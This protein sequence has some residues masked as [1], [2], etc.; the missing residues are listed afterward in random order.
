M[1]LS[2]HR[3]AG[4]RLVR[5]L[6]GGKRKAPHPDAPQGEIIS[7]FP[8]LGDENQPAIPS[9]VQL[10][11]LISSARLLKSVNRTWSN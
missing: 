4:K 6:T 10:G 5:R 3:D 2:E 1:L 8:T 7:R 11:S 9:F